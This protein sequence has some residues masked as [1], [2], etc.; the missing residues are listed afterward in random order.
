MKLTIKKPFAAT[1]AIAGA[2]ALAPTAGAASLF[3]DNFDSYAADSVIQGQG[4]FIYWNNSEDLDSHSTVS[5]EFAFSGANSLMIGGHGGA[6]YSDPVMQFADTGTGVSPMNE[7][8]WSYTS[9]V[10]I[11]SSSTTSYVDFNFMSSHPAPLTWG[12]NPHFNFENSMVEGTGSTPLAMIR[13][14]WFEFGFDV[15][16]DT[17]KGNFSING[18]ALSSDF[19]YDGANG[20]EFDGIDY[21]APAAAGALF[22]DD[23]EIGRTI[24]EPSASALSV[25]ACL[26]LALR[27]KR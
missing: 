18:V 4:D 15:D 19:D 2:A 26:G 16:L 5:N 25:L 13:D 27:R 3:S 12:G 20:M 17:G 14:E 11:P 6:H 1:L 10:Y 9:M 22:V 23:I 24:P 8:Q 21:W 7:G